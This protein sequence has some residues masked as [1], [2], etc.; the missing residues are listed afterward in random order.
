MNTNGNVNNNNA[1]NSLGVA[2]GF[3]IARPNNLARGE[4]KAVQ[5]Q[6]GEATS[7]T[8][9][10]RPPAQCHKPGRHDAGAQHKG[11]TTN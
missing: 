5:M 9:R 11:A 2:P 1:N 10:A 4:A 6:K 7:Q 8:A 3:R